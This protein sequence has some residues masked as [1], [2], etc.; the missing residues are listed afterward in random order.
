MA[1]PMKRKDFVR[2]IEQAGW[3]LRGPGS[4]HDIY[5]KKTEHYSVPRHTEV[6]AGIVGTWKK[7]NRNLDKEN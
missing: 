2:M 1:K 3:V 5:E 6:S 4:E 7:I